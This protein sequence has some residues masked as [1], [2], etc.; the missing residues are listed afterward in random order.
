MRPKASSTSPPPSLGAKRL[1]PAG[2][3][4]TVHREVFHA[5]QTPLSA[6]VITAVKK[7]PTTA[8]SSSR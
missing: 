8:S 2:I 4:R 3:G 6:R 7:R 1:A 5:Q